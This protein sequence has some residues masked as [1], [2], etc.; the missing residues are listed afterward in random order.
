M[1]TRLI[2]FER[3]L[4]ALLRQAWRVTQNLWWGIARRQRTITRRRSSKSHPT[5]FSSWTAATCSQLG[6]L[7]STSQTH[8]RTPRWRGRAWKTFKYSFR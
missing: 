1:S 3:F 2:V 7:F 5:G 6:R 4:T 8:H